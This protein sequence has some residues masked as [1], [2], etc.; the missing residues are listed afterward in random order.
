MRAHAGNI[1]WYVALELMWG[2]ALAKAMASASVR[3]LPE[4]LGQAM[5]RNVF[6]SFSVALPCDPCILNKRFLVRG[7]HATL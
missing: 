1:E 2:R 6:K 7:V 4:G 5:A 3:V